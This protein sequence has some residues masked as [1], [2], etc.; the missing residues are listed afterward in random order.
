[1]KIASH[2]LVIFGVVA[3]GC[4]LAGCEKPPVMSEASVNV[5]PIKQGEF[6]GEVTQATNAV[7]VDFYA[8]WCGPCQRL[9]PML[10]KLAAG[11]T[12]QVKFVK[13][14]VDEA[15][16]LAKEFDVRAIPMLIFFKD[17]KPVDHIIG[18]PSEA[19]LKSRLDTL[20]AVK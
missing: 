2:R 8:T 20:A 18:L 1:M 17:G 7:V 10:D 19:D 6:A 5:K 11:Y 13:V 14:D 15:T 4:I 3:L 12:N 16:A 9:S